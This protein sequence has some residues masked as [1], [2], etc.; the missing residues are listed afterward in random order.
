MQLETLGTTI[1]RRSALTVT[2]EEEGD[3]T[4]SDDV[5]TKEIAALDEY[6]HRKN[7]G[8]LT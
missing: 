3:V 8:A 6:L 1:S 7:E 4:K 5:L 2:G